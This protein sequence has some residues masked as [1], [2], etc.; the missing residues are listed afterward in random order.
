VLSRRPRHAAWVLEGQARCIAS[1]DEL[2][3]NTH[4]DVVVNLA[5]ARVLGWRWSAARKTQLLHSRV[6]LTQTV[7]DW[8]AQTAHKPRLLLSASAI[9]YY[10]I[11]ARGDA[12]GLGEDSPPQPIFM[13]QLCQQWEAA[14][15]A[16]QAHGTR[17]V[18]FRLGLVLGHGGPLPM[19]LM[20]IRLSLGGPL[21][22]G[23]QSFSWIHVQDVLRAMAHVWQQADV[24]AQ[25]VSGAWNFTAS[26]VPTQAQFTRTAAQVLHRPAFVPVPALPVRWALGEQADLLLEGQRVLPARLQATSFVFTHPT[27]RSALEDLA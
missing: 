19:M 5:G 14:A 24:A 3:A 21:G 10:G 26:E 18:C 23:Q 13:S 7:V 15:H 6:A 2:P 9:G 16:A 25:D 1:M 17:V 27:L 12:A 8:I 11:Q 20:P 4:I 22:H